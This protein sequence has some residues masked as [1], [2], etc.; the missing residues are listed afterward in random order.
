MPVLLFI[1]WVLFHYFVQSFEGDGFSKFSVNQNR[2]LSKHC[3]KIY[4]GIIKE[5]QCFRICP[6]VV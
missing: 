6:S 5:D 3:V 2:V 4:E 1:C